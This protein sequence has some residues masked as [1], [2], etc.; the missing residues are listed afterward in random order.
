MA[1]VTI[2]LHIRAQPVD[3][4]DL[5]VCLFT[6]V[7]KKYFSDLGCEGILTFCTYESS[8]KGRVHLCLENTWLQSEFFSE[9]SKL[10][11]P[12]DGFLD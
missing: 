5:F 1:L 3:L 2:L 6:T 12:N 4:R 11:D 7:M 9:L 8:E 10:F